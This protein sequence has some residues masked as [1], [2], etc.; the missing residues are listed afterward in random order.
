MN[1][2][3]AATLAPGIAKGIEDVSVAKTALSA[4]VA[5]AQSDCEHQIVSEVPWKGSEY[6]APLNAMRI[7]NHCRLV[8][9]GSHWSGGSVW[10]RHDFGRSELGNIEGR[11]I[12][13]VDRD[14]FYAM[15]VA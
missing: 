11:I 12:Q 9:E 5:A 15:R 4:A 8:E 13:P 10:S 1:L 2:L 3:P 6:F 7:C 14:T